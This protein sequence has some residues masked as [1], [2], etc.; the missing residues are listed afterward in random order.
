MSNAARS[1]ACCL[2]ALSLA[3]CGESAATP[4]EPGPE[5]DAG[6][7]GAIGTLGAPCSPA[8]ALACAGRAQKLQLLCDGSKWV[9]NGVC[10]GQ[11]ICDTRVGTT[12]GSCQDPAPGC[13]G[14]TPGAS[15]CDGATRKTCGPDLVTVVSNPCIDEQHCRDGVGSECAKSCTAGTYRCSLDT[16]EVCNASGAGYDPV[17]ICPPGSCD[18]ASKSCVECKSGEKGCNFNTPRACDSSGHWKE[19]A[20]CSGA[21]PYCNNGLCVDK[22]I[23]TFSQSFTGG[24]VNAAKCSAWN[25]FRSSLTGTY[26]KI[27]LKGTSDPVGVSCTGTTADKLCGRLLSATALGPYGPVT[28]DGNSWRV[29]ADC[30]VASSVE[31]AAVSGSTALACGCDAGW[32]VRPCI[33]NVDWGGMAMS[34]C[35]P[36]SQTL[37]VICE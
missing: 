24:V 7:P 19:L 32:I 18:V 33:G 5:E 22:P 9:S 15:F 30:G 35:S 3:G 37:T 4:P 13:A 26:S 29:G 31:I 34:P 16:L 28:C 23:S 36:V 10:P 14:K 1:L 6:P 8:G 25:S 2:V 17:K 12:A 27:T 11:Q 21:T 20:P